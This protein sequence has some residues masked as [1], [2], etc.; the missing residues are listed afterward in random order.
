MV[1]LPISVL[2]TY[3]LRQAHGFETFSYV[4]EQESFQVAV[5]VLEDRR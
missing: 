2:K 1:K 5:Y 4:H 3:L